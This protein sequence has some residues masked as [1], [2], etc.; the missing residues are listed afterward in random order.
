MDRDLFMMNSVFDGVTR[1]T[2]STAYKLQ[3]D[4]GMFVIPLTARYL[5]Y[6][7]SVFEPALLLKLI[8]L[9]TL[10][11]LYLSHSQS[12]TNLHITKIQQKP[13]LHSMQIRFVLQLSLLLTI[14]LTMIHLSFKAA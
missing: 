1:L 4:H 7:K 10:Y 9:R 2:A 11:V 3:A 6:I 12:H 5:R 13:Y 8:R 14:T